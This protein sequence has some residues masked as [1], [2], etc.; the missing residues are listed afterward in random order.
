LTPL[1]VD[2]SVALKWIVQEAGS[3]PAALL[4]GHPLCA[5]ELLLAEC[6]NA[7]WKKV[8]RSEISASD[9]LLLADVLARADLDLVSHRLL[10]AHAL[11]LSVTLDHPAYG[12]LYLGLA[13]QRAARLVTADTRLLARLQ[14]SALAS[15]VVRLGAT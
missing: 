13:Q 7:F 5:L 14:G 9:T 11:E 8:R 4:L 10:L 3:E 15:R 12:C 6:T 2:A 1:L